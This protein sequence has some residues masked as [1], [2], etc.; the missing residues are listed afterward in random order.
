MDGFYIAYHA[1]GTMAIV[2]IT[3]SNLK[4]PRAFLLRH[5]QLP[6]KRYLLAAVVSKPH[7]VIAGPFYHRSL[8]YACL[9][10][11]QKYGSKLP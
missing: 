4:V 6:P 3:L 2:Q 10:L 8:F 1:D 9:F 11:G 7:F 5:L